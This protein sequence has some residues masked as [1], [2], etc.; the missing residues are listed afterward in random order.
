[1]EM[2]VCIL[3]LLRMIKY[4]LWMRVFQQ[5]KD[6]VGDTQNSRIERMSLVLKIFTQRIEIV[7]F[8][9]F[10]SQNLWKNSKSSPMINDSCSLEAV[11][12]CIKVCVYRFKF[13]KSLSPRLHSYIHRPYSFQI[14]SSDICGFLRNFIYLKFIQI[15]INRCGYIAIVQSKISLVKCK[16]LDIIKCLKFRLIQFL[17]HPQND[18]KFWLFDCDE[19]RSFYFG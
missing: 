4:L 18:F 1:M 10:S 9:F 17:F 6:E 19:M 12:H 11:R 13:I 16:S 3:K 8:K 14:E 15:K 2:G 7:F 5:L